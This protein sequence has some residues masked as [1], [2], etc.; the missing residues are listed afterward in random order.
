MQISSSNICGAT[1]P[2]FFFPCSINNEI[3]FWKIP[4]HRPLKAPGW[5]NDLFF[6]FFSNSEKYVTV[7][8]HWILNIWLL[9]QFFLFFFLFNRLI[10]NSMGNSFNCYN[11]T[12]FYS[13]WENFVLDL[14]STIIFLSSRQTFGIFCTW[15]I[16]NSSVIVILSVYLKIQ[17]V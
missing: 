10:D 12:Q 5:L 11:F 6:V 13:C 9:Y 17:I 15:N 3:K 7:S 16:P 14:F 4:G 2:H 1:R 8:N